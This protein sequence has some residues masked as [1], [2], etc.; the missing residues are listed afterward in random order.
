MPRYSLERWTA[1]V[2]QEGDYRVIILNP[3]T[4][5]REAARERQRRWMAKN[6]RRLRGKKKNRCPI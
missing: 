2:I 4:E 1:E 5:E 6:G 3:W